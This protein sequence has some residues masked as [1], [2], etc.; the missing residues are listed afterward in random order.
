MTHTEIFCLCYHRRI[1]KEFIFLSEERP[2]GVIQGV[3]FDFTSVFEE[4]N[5]KDI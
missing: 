5:L 2:V 3:L 1:K 4:L